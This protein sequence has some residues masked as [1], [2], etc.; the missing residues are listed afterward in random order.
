MDRL[1]VLVLFGGQSEEHDISCLS[2]T[3]ICNNLD[4]SRY[5]LTL[6]GVTREGRWLLTESVSAIK[7]GSWRNGETGAVLLP[8]ATKKALLISYPDGRT[9]EKPVELVIPVFHGRWG[10]DGTVQGLFELARI[11][12]VGCGVAAS[13]CGM[14]KPYTKVLVAAAGVEQA[15]FV[16][17][18]PRDLKD[19]DAVVKR[20]EE[21][22]DYPIFVKP[23]DGGSSQGCSRAR[24]REDLV[25]ALELA[26]RYGTRVMAEENI[27]G[28]ELECAVRSTQ[29]GPKASGVGE[30]LSAASADFYDFDA[31]YSNPDSQ[32]VTDPDLPEGKAEEIR[33][34]A[35]KVFEAV[36]AYGLSR[37]DF[38]LENGTNR[39]IFNE[40]NTFPGFTSI[41]MYP[42][43]WAAAGLPI[44]QLL[45]ALIEE[46]LRRGA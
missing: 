37:V 12:Y 22:F 26:A 35:V 40:I 45:D 4:R 21:T 23:S 42:Q 16:S 15:R 27:T 19:M 43:L 46:G 14:D 28:R 32:T 34:D 29:D 7:D 39:V 13:A 10:E 20:L 6:V 38:F 44:P 18:T 2:A 8:D 5:D 24:N 11:P 9:E 17:L 36:G 41:S 33:R 3:T 30:I 31:K 25:G 1:K